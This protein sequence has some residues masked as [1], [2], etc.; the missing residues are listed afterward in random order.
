MKHASFNCSFNSTTSTSSTSPENAGPPAA[1]GRPRTPVLGGVGPPKT[2]SPSS[3]SPSPPTL[4][5]GVMIYSNSSSGSNKS[6][7]LQK[8]PSCRN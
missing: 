3:L 1:P 6:G 7:R 8:A 2:P 4:A 5:N